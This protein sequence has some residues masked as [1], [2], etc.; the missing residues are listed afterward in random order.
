[1]KLKTKITALVLLLVAGFAFSQNTG[2]TEKKIP[3]K[4]GEVESRVEETN[5]Q[6]DTTITSI[7][8][9]IDG[10]KEAVTKVSEILFGK[11]DKNKVSKSNIIILIS[12]I[13]YNDEGLTLLYNDI[14]KANGAKKTTKTF[15]NGVAII[16]I[17]SKATADA[18]WQN[19]QNKIRDKFEID[20]IGE[21][22]IKIFPKKA[23]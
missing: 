16:T 3:N 12:S 23:K 21:K 19:I 15:T 10:A 5:Q 13:A 22:E 8:N 4:A 17:E 20:A 6:I 11:K 7:D 1:M 9:T 2:E 18:V 14:S